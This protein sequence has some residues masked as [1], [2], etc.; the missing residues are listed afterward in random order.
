MASS[1]SLNTQEA[2]D[3]NDVPSGMHAPSLMPEVWCPYFLSPNGPITITDSVMLN[4]VTATAIAAGLYTPK[5]GKVLAGRTDPQII[6]D[7]MAFTI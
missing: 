3:P 7:S 1:S 5:D 6:Y 2:I 4:G